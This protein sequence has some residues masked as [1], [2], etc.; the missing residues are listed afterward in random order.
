MP[1]QT[2][3]QRRPFFA[4][5]GTMAVTLRLQTAALANLGLLRIPTEFPARR[6]RE[7]SRE[8]GP[9]NRAGKGRVA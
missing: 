9:G 2:K 1:R 5:W 7:L 4:G 3:Q 6:S 8:G